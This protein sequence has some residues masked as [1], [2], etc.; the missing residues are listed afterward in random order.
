MRVLR[1]DNQKTAVVG[2][3]RFN[4]PTI[5]HNELVNTLAEIASKN[6][7]DPLLYMSHKYKK[8]KDSRGYFKDP[9]KYEDKLY[10][11]KKAF[12]DRVNVLESDAKTIIQV[13][14]DLH[15]RGYKNIIYVGGSD[16]IGG[17][18]DITKTIE[19]YNGDPDSKGNILYDFD[20]INFVKAGKDRDE[21]SDDLVTSASAS[22]ARKYA[23]DGDLES[24]KEIVPLSDV[25]AEEMYNLVRAELG[26]TESLNEAPEGVSELKKTKYTDAVRKNL[27]LEL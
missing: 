3:G 13:F 25:D 12:G 10:F 18:G 27:E 26:I 20:S 7:A 8:D 24:F 15:A 23:I 17:A 16:R 14:Q 4:P 6:N 22:L 1:E 19:K 21:D 11:A 5:G 9:L 2:W